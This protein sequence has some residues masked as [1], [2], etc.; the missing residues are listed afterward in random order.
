[1]IE[2]DG[3]Y[4]EGGGQILRTSIGLASL[5]RKK[6]RIFN[7]RRGR[8]VPGLKEQHLQSIRM[9]RKFTDGYLEGDRLHSTEIIYEPGDKFKTSIKVN[10]RTAGAISL[11]LQPLLI[12]CAQDNFSVNLSI[13]GGATNTDM[14]PPLAYLENLLFP[15]LKK[16]GISCKLK[17]IREGFYPKGGAKV[18]LIVYTDKF[19]VPEMDLTLKPKIEIINGISIQ[20]EHLSRANV[21]SRQANSALKFLQEKSNFDIK[22]KKSTVKAYNP[23]SAI[24]LWSVGENFYLGADSL[25]KRGKPSEKVG[26]EAAEKLWFEILNDANIDSHLSDMIIPFIALGST[27]FKFKTSKITNHLKTNIWVVSKFIEDRFY[28]KDNIV[29]F[30]T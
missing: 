19:Q 30:A 2:I 14:S 15:L 26:R 18:Q 9:M 17:I 6:V 7:I 16:F 23:G 29:Y 8:K 24:V 21:A 22:I 28:I 20:T 1:M 5:L 3:S 13:D 10:I 4:L 12:A 25:G 11:L 27:P